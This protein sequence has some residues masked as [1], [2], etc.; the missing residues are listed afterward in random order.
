MKIK[1]IF[2][3]LLSQFVLY[4]QYFGERTTE[5]N[6]EQ[7]DFYF[8]SHYLNTFGMYSFK[9]V[10]AGFIKDPFLDLYLNPAFI[11]DLGE[12]EFLLYI[13]F[14][15]D[16]TEVPI[17]DSYIVPYYN[18]TAFYRPIFD[19]R[20]FS[21]SRSEPEPIFSLGILNYPLKDLTKNFFIGGTYQ[22]INRQ[23]KFYAVPYG[24]YYP[25]YY[26]DALGVRAEGVANIPI[27]ERY[28]GKDELSTSGHLFSV[29][30]GYKMLNELSAGLS[31]N[32]VIHSRDGEYA[33][34]YQD[35]FGQ[36][37]AYDHFSFSNQSRNQDYDHIDLSAGIMYDPSEKISVGA[38]IGY[39]KGK[40]EQVYSSSNKYFYEYNKANIS[41]EWNY[42]LSD[43]QNS[44]SWKQNGSSKYISVNFTRYIDD[45]K[46]FSGYYRYTN[47]DINLTNSGN[48]LDTSF[49]TS[50][51]YS[52]W[53]TSYSNYN[54]RSFTSDVR[55][56][57]GNRSIYMH[58]A[59]INFFWKLN[60]KTSVRTGIYYNST[61][62]KVNS[63]EPVL[64][65]RKSEYHYVYKNASYNYNY[66][67]IE[68]KLL[69][70][71]FESKSWSLQIPII[72]NFDIN[73]TWNIILGFNRILNGWQI[74]DRTTAY[75]KKR[76]KNDNG[77]VGVESNFGERYTQPSQKFTED[78]AKI[79]AGVNVCLSK[80][81][82][83]NLF[84]D[85]EFDNKIR[86][87]QW[88]LGFT[89]KL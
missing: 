32:G 22:L 76:Q 42:N 47:T 86:L 38:K 5:Q 41:D 24:I 33:N 43:Y 75:F 80:S 46:E 63:S 2:I 44:Q 50:R 88:W 26:Y 81:L 17:L 48:I 87:A 14:R 45:K 3:A 29:F 57:T 12:D 20:W 9:K 59:L 51:Y 36:P 60:E 56:G 55:S 74:E 64:A 78:F 66:E 73:E 89:A 49:Y 62:S 35:E 53:D 34:N 54:G 58:E 16:R 31:L 84:L 19:P 7:S 67:L 8:N 52:S 15:G 85:P 37:D 23:E 28:A 72:F 11:P 25:N 27:K 13:D 10:A 68:D 39:L 4:P 82:K 77:Q 21:K 69:E 30:T 70:W 61:N 71:E 40:A 79:V 18:T 6:F 65:A 83:I 1:I